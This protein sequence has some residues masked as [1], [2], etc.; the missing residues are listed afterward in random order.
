MLDAIRAKLHAVRGL[1]RGLLKN[2]RRDRVKGVSL[3]PE[4]QVRFPV[5]IE[6]RKPTTPAAGEGPGA[7]GLG[8]PAGT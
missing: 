8:K 2:A 1:R 6:N 7:E 3:V 4:Q 5:G